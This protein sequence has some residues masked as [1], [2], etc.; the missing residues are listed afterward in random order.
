MNMEILSIDYYRDCS[1]AGVFVSIDNSPERVEYLIHGHNFHN[2]RFD[3]TRD[4]WGVQN[5]PSNEELKEL[6]LALE[7][8]KHSEKYEGW[9]KT[10]EEIKYL[11]VN[12]HRLSGMVAVFRY[13]LNSQENPP[14]K[15]IVPPRE[16]VVEIVTTRLSNQIAEMMEADVLEKMQC[17]AIRDGQ[18]IF[19]PTPEGGFIKLRRNNEAE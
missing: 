7:D 3:V 8:F 12:A 1:T 4:G 10:E 14:T 11:E 6:G 9:Q 15:A 16:D 2:G 17:Y 5:Y 19:T 13:W 18:F